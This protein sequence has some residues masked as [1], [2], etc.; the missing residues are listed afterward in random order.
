MWFDSD[1]RAINRTLQRMSGHFFDLDDM[2][3]DAW[4]NFGSQSSYVFM[5]RPNYAAH[6][7]SNR[8]MKSPAMEPFVDDVLDEKSKTLKLIAEMPGVEKQDIKLTVQDRMAYISAERGERKYR[9]EIPLKYK[10]DENSAKA[11]YSNG[12]LEVTFALEDR[13]TGKQ[14]QVE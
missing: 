8:T 12:I 10:I 14:V 3:E 5:V 6:N 11:T 1:I 7:S 2:F 9:A 4:R 13:P